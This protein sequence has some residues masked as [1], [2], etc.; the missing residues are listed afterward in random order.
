MYEDG[1]KQ[2]D[3][4]LVYRCVVGRLADVNNC[5]HNGSNCNLGSLIR[6][7]VGNAIDGVVKCQ[8]DAQ[9]HLEM[10]ERHTPQRVQRVPSLEETNA[11]QHN[12]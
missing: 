3:F 6:S 8:A 9:D 7:V 1:T 2:R 10:M 11:Y 5:A 12:L 4:L